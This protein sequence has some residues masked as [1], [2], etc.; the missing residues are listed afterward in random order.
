M[1]KDGYLVSISTQFVLSI[2]FRVVCAKLST[3]DV[4]KQPIRRFAQRQRLDVRSA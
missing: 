1:S 2:L 3:D 4:T